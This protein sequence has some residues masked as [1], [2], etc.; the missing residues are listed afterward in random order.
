MNARSSSSRVGP[1]MVVMG[2]S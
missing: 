1:N 2:R